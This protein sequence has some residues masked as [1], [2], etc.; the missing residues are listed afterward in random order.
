MR[1]KT[2]NNDNYIYLCN[3]CLFR[4]VPSLL[5]ACNNINIFSAFFVS[6]FLVG[7]LSGQILAHCVASNMGKLATIE[8]VS[9]QS[10]NNALIFF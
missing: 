3:A 7:E 9:L 1:Y 2:E 8:K 6:L 10:F 5:V 4:R